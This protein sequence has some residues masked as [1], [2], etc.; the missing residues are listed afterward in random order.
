MVVED[1]GPG[2]GAGE[3]SRIFEK[4]YRGSA[5]RS[6]RG[7]GLGLWI[8]WAIVAAHQGTIEAENRVPNGA[9]FRVSLPIDER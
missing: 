7:A 2:I 4:F 3:E 9:R 6:T 5:S 8:S 1:E